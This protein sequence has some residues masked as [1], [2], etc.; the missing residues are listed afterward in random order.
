MKKYRYSCDGGTIMIGNPSSRVCITNNFGD[1][2]HSVYVYD[3]NDKFDS[4]GWDFKG[5]VE[6]DNL[7]VYDYDCLYGDDLSNPDH[8]LCTLTGRYAVYVSRGSVALEKW[9]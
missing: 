6:G 1:G 4:I 7:N 2:I 8:I 3:E 9:D 5:T